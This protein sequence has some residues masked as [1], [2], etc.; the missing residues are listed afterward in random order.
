MNDSERS[1]SLD[2][3]FIE[4]DGF[5]TALKWHRARKLRGDTPFTAARI[6]EG[7][8]A[9]ASVEIDLVRH[10][11]GGFAVLHDRTLDRET[12]GSGPVAEAAAAMLKQLKLRD[13]EGRPGE[14]GVMLI[15]DLGRV[16]AERPPAA[17][18]LLQLD[19][20]S[21]LPELTPLDVEVFAL[22]IAP[23]VDSVILSGGDA[24]ALR[25]L[26]EAVPGIRMGYDPSDDLDVAALAKADDFEG[27]V[28][29]SIA[30]LPEASMIYLHYPRVL[31]AAR[32][33]F[34]LIG[35]FHR[36]GRRVDAWTVNQV[37]PGIRADVEELLA[38]RCDQITA[39]EPVAL[40]LMMRNP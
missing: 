35:A 13:G 36:E 3:I 40:D 23:V 10:A 20:K 37:E 27:F 4:R 38:L 6:L 25:L 5:R 18:A 9:G 31:A 21:D 22:A 17:G 26:S 2:G 1:A 32:L 14:H 24:G 16:L 28:A 29:R 7:M 39:D 34:D 8:A 30:A 15:A 12:T 33:G 11:G 19:L